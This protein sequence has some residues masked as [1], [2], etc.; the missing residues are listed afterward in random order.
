MPS[1]TY[2]IHRMDSTLLPFIFL[3]H[4]EVKA[5]QTP[6]NWHENMELLY[7]Y[8]GAGRVHLGGERVPFE[9]GDL[10]AVNREVPH[11]IESE[12]EV[13]YCCLIVKDSFL[14]ENGLEP[15]AVAFRK[16]IRDQGPR[17]A[18]ESVRRAFNAY[19]P[20]APFSALQVRSAVL[21]LFCILTEHYAVPSIAPSEND[22][23]V[24]TVLHHIR[25]H[26][27]DPLCLDEL[28]ALAGVSKY[29]LSHV[30][31]RATGTS[32]MRAVILLRLADAHDRILKGERVSEAARACGFD[33]LSYFTRCFRERYGL[34]PSRLGK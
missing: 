21:N 31:R 23:V 6:P 18:M 32:P 26:F 3:P 10:V 34:L 16:R 9:T 17:E 12:G 13:C 33:N 22:G 7:C 29:H 15:S 30:F 8:R 20:D 27:A 28:A 5:R 1:F 25:L 19:E 11:L 24:L 14:R 2:E 4:L